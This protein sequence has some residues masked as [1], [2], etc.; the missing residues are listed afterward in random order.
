MMIKDKIDER[1]FSVKELV[2]RGIGSAATIGRLIR[3]GKLRSYKLGGSRKIAESD[4][5]AYLNSCRE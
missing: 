2:E 4:L 1:Y 5:A 3:S